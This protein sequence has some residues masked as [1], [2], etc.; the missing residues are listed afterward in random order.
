MTRS[1][2]DLVAE[3]RKRISRIAPADVDEVVDAGGLVIDIRPQQLREEE[4]PFPGAIVIERNVLEWRLDPQGDHRI[5]HVTGYDQP[6]IIVCSGGF[7]S[8]LAAA[9]LTDLG[10]SS[11][12]DL[13]GGYQAWRAWI[14]ADAVVQLDHY[15]ENL[16]RVATVRKR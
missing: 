1:A 2:D 5:P 4:G 8:S 15:R 9:A 6:V 3:A 10:F 14:D 13:E 16:E 11:A 7:A 12:A